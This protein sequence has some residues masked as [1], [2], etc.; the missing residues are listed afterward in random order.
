MN[1]PAVRTEEL[2]PAIASHPHRHAPARD[3]VASSWT[4]STARPWTARPWTQQLVGCVDLSG[5][6]VLSSRDPNPSSLCTPVTRTHTSTDQSARAA[7]HAD[8][9]GFAAPTIDSDLPAS[10]EH[11]TVTG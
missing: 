11:A 3:D 9:L 10:L 6:R 7:P 5:D 1:G 2:R 4:R 8:R